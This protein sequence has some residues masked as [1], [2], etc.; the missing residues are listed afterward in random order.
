MWVALKLFADV[1]ILVLV[2]SL[3]VF[4]TWLFVERLRAGERAPR[5]FGRWLVDVWDVISGLG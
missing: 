1:A 3:I 2:A 4:V 5:S